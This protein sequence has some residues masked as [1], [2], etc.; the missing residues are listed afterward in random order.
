M[1]DL[2]DNKIALY[3]KLGNKQR[4]VPTSVVGGSVASVLKSIVVGKRPK[5][6]DILTL[7]EGEKEYLAGI[8]MAAKIS[9]LEEMPTK[10]KSELEKEMHEFEVLKGQIGAGNDNP[11]LIK[12]FKTAL[13]KMVRAKKVNNKQAQEILLELADLGH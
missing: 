9:D 5:P 8:G 2:K 3:T 12:E 13:V 11:K 7:D 4:R 6:K 10:K 1:Q